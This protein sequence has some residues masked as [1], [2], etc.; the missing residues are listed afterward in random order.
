MFQPKSDAVSLGYDS[1]LIPCRNGLDFGENNQVVWDIPRNVGM[2]Q[3]K[4]ARVLV[5]ININGSAG[6]PLVQPD[7]IVGGNSFF[8]RIT[9]RSS[10]RVIEQLDS[11]NVFAKVHYSATDDEGVMNKRSLLE[12]CAPSYRVY[13]NPFA[14]INKVETQAVA[15]N[16]ANA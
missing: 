10:G 7:R 5:D 6:A 14:S 2:A 12:G 16:N 13:D 1:M 11:Y 15:I 8:D 9:I 4:D 3:L